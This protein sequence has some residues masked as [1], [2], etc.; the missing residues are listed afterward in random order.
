MQI[1]R[2]SSAFKKWSENGRCKKIY[3][4]YHVAYMVNARSNL[5][6]VVSAPG[7]R[8]PK[9]VCAISADATTAAAYREDHK[10]GK[11]P[12]LASTL[13]NKWKAFESQRVCRCMDRTG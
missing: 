9:I 6:L 7:S 11:G 13:L 10:D 5:R 8:P 3:P 2:V 4:L 12:E 1:T